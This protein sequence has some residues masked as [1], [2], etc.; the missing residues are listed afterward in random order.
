MLLLHA[1]KAGDILHGQHILGNGN[2]SIKSNAEI[3]VFVVEKNS[4]EVITEVEAI[5]P[6]YDKIKNL[7]SIVGYITREG[8]TLWDIAK[9]YCTTIAQIRES[10]EITTDEIE[11]GTKLLLTKIC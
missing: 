1:E 8:D 11:P 10:N 7:P 4:T 5:A 2:V 3:I 6:D 9:K